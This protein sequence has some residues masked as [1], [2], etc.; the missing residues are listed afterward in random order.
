M[1]AQLKVLIPLFVLF[2]V[3]FLVVR[4]FLVPE[5]FGEY[6][7]YRGSALEDV[8]A[9]EITYVGKEACV[10]CHKEQAEIMEY[11]LHSELSCEVCHGPGLSHV[12]EPEKKGLLE[13]PLSRAS[14]GICHS[15]E[16]LRNRDYINQ[17]DIKGHHP[18]RETCID[19]HNPH[20]VWEMKE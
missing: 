5:S 14:C 6:G 3:V 16:A 7:F 11:D 17:I 15:M 8:A 20:A 4:S 13:M 12:N 10:E 18:E 9:L 2:V 19:C 1:P